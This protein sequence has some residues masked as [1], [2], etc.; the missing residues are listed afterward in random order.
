MRS[1]KELDMSKFRLLGAALALAAIPLLGFT[2]ASAQTKRAKP[3]LTLEQA[4]KRCTPY[5]QQIPDWNVQGRT[6]RGKT[7]MLRYGYQI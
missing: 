6:A 3:K 1:D 4:W 5:A 7:C 2:D